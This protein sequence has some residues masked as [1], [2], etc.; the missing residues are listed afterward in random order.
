MKQ[1]LDETPDCPYITTPSAVFSSSIESIFLPV[2]LSHPPPGY[3]GENAY[4]VN[5]SHTVVLCSLINVS[6]LCYR[7]RWEENC[8]EENKPVRKPER[9]VLPLLASLF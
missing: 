7:R 6:F 5:Q 9:N 8:W 1:P 2:S 3:E 4:L